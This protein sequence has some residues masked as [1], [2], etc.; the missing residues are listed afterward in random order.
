[1][2]TC[3]T[4]VGCPLRTCQTLSLNFKIGPVSHGEN[5]LSV[6]QLSLN[7]HLSLFLDI[8]ILVYNETNISN[9]VLKQLLC[10]KDAIRCY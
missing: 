3:V 4:K 7:T 2:S 5:L 9:N 8:S 10:Y 1:M 6:S